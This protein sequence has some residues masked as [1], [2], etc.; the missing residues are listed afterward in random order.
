MTNLEPDAIL[1]NDLCVTCIIGDLPHE[2][3]TPQELFLDL[4]LSCD[5]RPAAQSDALA[6]TVDY[7]AVVE[8]VRDTLT[9][10][11]CRMIERAAQLAIDAVFAVD[12]R[13]RACRLLLRK[14]QALS[15]VVAAV[16]LARTRP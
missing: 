2:R 4:E 9:Q 5:L 12:P 1:L 10:A 16:R 3:I 6:D 13:I 15:G 7:V 8:A 14:P 11:R